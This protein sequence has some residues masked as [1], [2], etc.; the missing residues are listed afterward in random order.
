MKV[1]Y[2]HPMHITV[3]RLL[4]ILICFY[5]SL[6][7]ACQILVE[8]LDY[9]WEPPCLRLPASLS[10]FTTSQNGCVMT[11]TA[12]RHQNSAT[13]FLNKLSYENMPVPE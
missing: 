13:H 8:T 4:Y 6:Q 9:T 10:I 1:K 2:L 3:D 12:K 11:G 5:F 7:N